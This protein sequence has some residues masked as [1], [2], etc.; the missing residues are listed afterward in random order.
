MTCD[1]TSFFNSGIRTM[2]GDNE[3]SRAAEPHLQSKRFLLL[4][5]LKPGTAKS[6]GQCLTY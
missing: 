6:A 3:R 1:F 2:V 4:A 5:G